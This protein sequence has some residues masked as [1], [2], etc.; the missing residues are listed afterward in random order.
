MSI[1]KIK[2]SEGYQLKIMTELLSTNFQ[3]ACFDFS[4]NGIYLRQMDQN[5]RILIDIKMDKTNF[6]K[7][8]FNYDS[9]MLIGINLNYL[10]KIL[11][12]VK[13]KD[14]LQLFMDSDDKLAVRTIPKENQRQTTSF[15]AVKKIQH[16]DI[17]IPE[18]YL[19][20]VTIS[21]SEFQKM[22]KDLVSLEN[23]INISATKS[24]L[25]FSC[26]IGNLFSR[27]VAF[28]DF[29]ED[30]E[31]IYNKTFSS[32]HLVKISKMA[33]L[34]NNIKIFVCQDKPLLFESNISSLGHIS[35]FL[36]ANEDIDH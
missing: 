28:G 24:G 23:L 14:T 7:Y 34:S 25:R 10:Q 30:D 26:E 11:K 31:M 2:T 15:V 35:I 17:D 6:N 27:E 13:K 18:D 1:F 20:N 22:V 21:S 32:K 19:H 9:N 5:Q 3:D 12:I 16:I 4:E 33:G 36:K 8:D 29:D